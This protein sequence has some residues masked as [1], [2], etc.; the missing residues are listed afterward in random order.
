M[1]ARGRSLDLPLPWKFS[2][3]PS[4]LYFSSWVLKSSLFQQK[5]ISLRYGLMFLNMDHKEDRK[6]IVSWERVRKAEFGVWS[7][8]LS[9]VSGCKGD[10]QELA[11]LCCVL[12]LTAS[13]NRTQ[14]AGSPSSSPGWGVRGPHSP[15]A[16]PPSDSH[17]G[18]HCWEL[19][20]A[21]GNQAPQLRKVE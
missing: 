10:L 4:Y 6:E 8:W 20:R 13:Q 14:R 17:V 11:E 3:F 9:W 7:R 19:F 1:V 12:T 16:R 15:P 2:L 18:C 21:A 5:D